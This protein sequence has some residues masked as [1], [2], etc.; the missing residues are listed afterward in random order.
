MKQ[1][2]SISFIIP[3]FN[4]GEKLNRC[5]QSIEKEAA[6]LIFEIIIIDDKSTDKATLRI[7]ESIKGK[8]NIK[9]IKNKN[10]KGAGHSRNVGLRVCTGSHI[11]FIDSDDTIS[12]N[13]FADIKNII[14]MHDLILFRYNIIN[15]GIVG[16]ESH[17]DMAI[18]NSIIKKLGGSGYFSAVDLPWVSRL[19]NYIWG[20]IISK[21]FAE[22][23][24]LNFSETH[25]YNDAFA[26]W[27]I[28]SL[29][30]TILFIDRP[31]VDYYKD[32]SGDQLT[33]TKGQRRIE[34]II[35]F[36]HA[37]ELIKGSVFIP[38][39]EKSKESRLN[40]VGKMDPENI[41]QYN[42]PVRE[43]VYD[44]D[45][46]IYIYGTGSKAFSFYN[47]V[48]IKENILGFI[49]SDKNKSGQEFMGKPVHHPEDLDRSSRI[50]IASSFVDEITNLIKQL[51]FK[52]YMYV[53][54]CTLVLADDT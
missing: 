54:E 9:I 33:K 16:R 31:L 39:L 23:I 14:G 15:N 17:N 13:A 40:W 26:F 44:V 24:N 7:L 30:N 2:S 53:E 19:T 36:E 1:T 29:S 43:T 22:K 5:I 35:V 18:Y 4:P 34:S 46:K 6:G 48:N 42:L 47:S 50:I 21:Q 52:N 41:S 10:N 38:Y 32:N 12:Q 11:C 20:K 45:Q 27:Q 3:C 8:K 37:A 51:G 25:C 28:I 49:D